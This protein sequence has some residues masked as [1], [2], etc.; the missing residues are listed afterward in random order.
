MKDAIT[1]EGVKGIIAGLLL[2]IASLTS[3]QLL[4][5]CTIAYVAIQTAYLV[6][7]WWREEHPRRKTRLY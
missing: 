3:S 2:W 5:Y 6:R 4:T 1:W 7:K